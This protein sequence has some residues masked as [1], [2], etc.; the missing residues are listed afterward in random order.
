[1]KKKKVVSLGEMLLRL[2]P[3]GYKTMAQAD[4]LQCQFGGSEL[5]V[6]CTLAQLG[7]PVSFVSAI[8]HNDLG[9]AAE[10]FLF[11]KQIDTTFVHKGGDR[12][13]IYF[14][15]KGFSL[16]RSTVMYDRKYSSFYFSKREDYPFEEIFK[17]ADWFHVSGITP[18]LNDEV[19]AITKEAMEFARQKGIHI[20]FDLNYRALLWNS[21]E[22][23]RTKLSVL[24]S[25]ADVCIG[26]EPLS[27]LGEDGVD[28]K[29]K[30]KIRMPYEK[31]Q[32]V[33]LLKGLSEQ[34]GLKYI[35]FTQRELSY[36]NEYQLKAFLFNGEDLLET[37]TEGIQVLDRVGTGDAFTAGII[38]GLL[39][40]MTD[41]DMLRYAMAIFKFKHTIDGDV[42]VMTEDD[43][44][45]ML[46]V[47][48]KE[49]RR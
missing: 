10:Q 21:F 26:F 7:Y 18:A 14:Y 2:S 9:K 40:E 42:N 4:T 22:E 13:G 46:D 20:S 37:D 12:L 8:P 45:Q 23:A 41:I 25:L 34:Y 39:E 47:E 24:A 36:N 19:Y 32:M 3:I 16:R 38:Y 44:L 33:P 35:A 17:E 29:D 48:A 27:L 1:M 49:I 6:L 28:L 43:V 31:E 30:E 15:Q 11:S 5:N